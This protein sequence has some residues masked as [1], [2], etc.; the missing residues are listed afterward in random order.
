MFNITYLEVEFVRSGLKL[1][2]W[3]TTKSSLQRFAPP[4][5]PGTVPSI[6]SPFPVLTRVTLLQKISIQGPCDF[7]FFIAILVQSL[8][9]YLHDFFLSSA[10]IRGY[11]L[12]GCSRVQSVLSYTVEQSRLTMFAHVPAVSV[13]R[14]CQCF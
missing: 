1:E 14:W 3:N 5:L 11:I 6:C 7:L 10:Y 12:T 4:P 13:A 9:K 2:V 8:L